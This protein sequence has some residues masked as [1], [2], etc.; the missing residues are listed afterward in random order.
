MSN[1]I[2]PHFYITLDD[3]K[4]ID[5]AEIS[6][7]KSS[8]REIH[9]LA[10]PSEQELQEMKEFRE[11]KDQILQDAESVAEEQIRTA[12][13]E[14]SALREQAQSE[15]DGWWHERRE[16]D[17]QVEDEAK[18]AGYEAGYQEG[19]R[20]AGEQ[21]RLQYE[22]LLSEAKSVLE[23]AY[24]MKSQIIKE[25]EPFLIE[26]SAAIAEKIIQHEL[27][28]NPEWI[29]GMTR[30]V[31]SRKREKGVITLCVAPNQ[32][33]YIRDARDELQLSIDSQAELQILPDSTVGDQGC[34]VRTAF[35]SVDA[36]VDTQLKEIKHALQQVSMEPEEG[37]EEL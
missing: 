34:V 1:V 29:I 30:S 20:E 23:Q 28:S 13:Q 36:R 16:L 31:L 19:V 25:S 4:H 3:K 14:A 22:S 33:A 12:M 15:I 18:R 27:S 11:M 21:V 5:V 35:G 24:A 2:K 10:G 6:I 9:G 8:T 37:A 17:Q 26:L 7:P 32:F